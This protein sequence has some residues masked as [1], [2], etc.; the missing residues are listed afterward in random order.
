MKY[1]KEVLEEAVKQSFSV[2]E[3]LRK[4]GIA[5]GGSHGYITRRIK[6]LCIDTSHF[7]KHGENLKEF[8]PKKP[9]QE[10][11]VLNLSNKRTRGVQLRQALL[12]MGREYKCENPKCSIQSEW[13]GRKIVLDVD[14]INGNWQD[15]RPG[16]VRFLC[17]NCH[18]QTATYGNKRRQVERKKYVSQPNKKV[19]HMKARKVERPSKEELAKMIWEKPTTHIAKDFG[20]SSKAI[21]KWCKAYEIQKPPRGYWNK[22]NQSPSIMLNQSK[23]LD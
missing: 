21:E 4:L 14:H 19:P 22:H 10:V 3:V 7:K 1:T 2:S 13:L 11:L 12:E 5:G 18:R 15:N 9:W 16:N 17:P 8:R 20:V 6:E 23:L